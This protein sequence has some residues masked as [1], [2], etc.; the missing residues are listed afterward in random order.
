MYIHLYMFILHH[1]HIIIP[2]IESHKNTLNDGTQRY[3]II[4]THRKGQQTNKRRNNQI[5]TK[6]RL[7]IYATLKNSLTSITTK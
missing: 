3:Q 4:K 2:N 6:Y 5:K 1:C 7:D